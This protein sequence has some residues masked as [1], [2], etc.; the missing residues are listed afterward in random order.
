MPEPD[1][2]WN[3]H[4]TPNPS[5]KSLSILIPQMEVKEKKILF[6]AYL[7][8]A[9]FQDCPVIPDEGLVE[10]YG[11]FVFT[12]STDADNKYLRYWFAAPKTAQEKMLPFRAMWKKFGN[13][14]HAPMLQG[15][16]F[17]TDP[18]FPLSTNIIEGGQL[19]VATAPRQYAREIFIAEVNEGSRFW[20]EEFLSPTPFAIGRY[21][22]PQPQP[23]PYQMNGISGRVEDCLHDDI[24]IPVTRSTTVTYAGGTES[25]SNAVVPGQ[26][27]PRTGFIRRRPYILIADQDLVNGVWYMQRI[28]V[29][30][31]RT[32]KVT[33]Q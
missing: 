4:R 9:L 7:P 10:D 28:R 11:D 15:L 19:G 23:V 18:N 26:F 22:V 1:P 30:P 13:H 16:A 24:E 29:F 31:P 32:P 12:D 33:V 14:R 27:F 3:L 5:E 8:G 21:P 6:D 20:L 17:V 2:R 25:S